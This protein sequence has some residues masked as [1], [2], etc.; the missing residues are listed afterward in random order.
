MKKLIAA[1]IIITLATVSP[2]VAHEGWTLGDYI[3]PTPF[4]SE[5]IDCDDIT[6]YSFYYIKARAPNLDIEIK[7]GYEWNH[8]WLEVSD[9][10]STF[11]YDYGVAYESSPAIDEIFI[12]RRITL[13]QL[14]GYIY[15]DLN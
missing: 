8:V 10:E 9:N 12:G 5:T 14:V 7:R 15:R 6:L 3:S 4:P 13:R 11:I 2:A 1:L